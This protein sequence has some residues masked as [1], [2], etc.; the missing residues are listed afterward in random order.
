MKDIWSSTCEDSTLNPW[1]RGD[2]CNEGKLR[3]IP[4]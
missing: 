4:F 2:V 3:S 1:A